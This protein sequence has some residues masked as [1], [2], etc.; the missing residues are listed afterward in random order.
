MANE[1]SL[2]AASVLNSG[3]GGGGRAFQALIQQQEAQGE[4]FQK[5]L[6]TIEQLQ[7]EN[8]EAVQA[9][10]QS[11]AGAATE[12]AN[13]IAANIDRENAKA[14]RTRERQEDKEFSRE[15]A[16]TTAKLQKEA[17]LEAA[18][19]GALLTAQRDDRLAWMDNF[20]G[21]KKAFEA[22]GIEFEARV[23][24]LVA[25]GMYDS[26]KG[27]DRLKKIYNFMEWSEA[28]GE[29][30]FDNRYR[31]AAQKLYNENIDD[32]FEGKDPRDMS[33]L[34][35]NPL[36]E[37]YTDLKSSGKALADP[38]TLT[39]DKMFELKVHGGYP[40]EGVLF[41]NQK[42]FGL[43]AGH[44]PTFTNVKTMRK[45]ILS[46]ET[47]NF[48][49]DSSIRREA[50]RNYQNLVLQTTERLEPMYEQYKSFNGMFGALS[51]AAFEKGIK[52]FL[53]NPDPNKFDDIG[54]AISENV[55]SEIYGGGDAG[56]KMAS[57]AMDVF[58]GKI[59]PATEGELAVVMA[60]ESA[61]FSL[62]THARTALQSAGEDGGTLATTLA[63]QMKGELGDEGFARMMGVEN[64]GP[65]FVAALGKLT[66]TLNETHGFMGRLNQGM[67][68]VGILEYFRDEMGE[69]ARNG[70]IIAMVTVREA[71]DPDK[72]IGKILGRDAAFDKVQG[73]IESASTEQV[74]DLVS[75]IDTEQIEETLSFVDATLS[76]VEGFGPDQQ[77]G[78]HTLLAAQLEG[79]EPENLQSFID[80]SKKMRTQ[81]TYVTAAGDRAGFTYKRHLE[82]AKKRKEA[83][84]SETVGGGFQKSGV[85]GTVPPL[86]SIAK[87]KIGVGLEHVG[88]GL[89]KMAAGQEAA[90]NFRRGAGVL[91]EAIRSPRVV[92]EALRPQAPP[93]QPQPL[94]GPPS[95]PQLEEEGTP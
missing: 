3:G 7:K 35:R 25:A 65:G 89:V 67:K 47:W 30:H 31:V 74:G 23:D 49:N 71:G 40:K 63:A 15:M 86:L 26:P 85:F 39:P 45:A 33:D 81:S 57:W 48:M 27:R 90:Q 56:K 46:D 92:P 22:T 59:E 80:D 94:E 14:D 9:A 70:D 84:D 79:I 51:P 29:D 11:A 10:G 54:R 19:M 83:G 50:L 61:S 36:L 53:V 69:A 95:P 87:S 8:S 75:N 21:K 72:R 44:E 77:R 38:G 4:Q 43:P 13:S 18:K 60:L 20:E 64:S 62:K 55:I 93:T 2:S 58:D 41:N 82:L 76:L 17:G 16:A 32:I 91:G 24:Q 52:N 88:A 28:M 73:I 12:V 34:T 68:N 5:L 1:K 6:Q 78:L 42:N 66:E 37:K